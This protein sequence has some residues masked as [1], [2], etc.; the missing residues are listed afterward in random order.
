[1]VEAWD[2]LGRMIPNKQIR[3]I[4]ELLETG[5]N[6]GIVRL[7]D[8]FTYEDF[9]THKWTILSTFVMLAYQESKQKGE[10]VA[11]AWKSRRDRVRAGNGSLPCQ[12]P[13]WCEVANYE[14]GK[15]GTVRLIP[16]RAAAV[17]RIYQLAGQGYGAVRIIQQLT[18]EKIKP[19]S[20]H[21]TRAYVHRILTERLALGEIQL[22][23]REGNP[24]G[25][26]IKGYLPAVVGEDEYAVAQAA[27]KG[28]KVNGRSARDSKHV[29]VFKGMLVHARD[30][31]PFHLH[32]TGSGGLALRNRSGDLG[33]DRNYTFP[34][35]VFEAGI[36]ALLKEVDP[37]DV[38]PHA[39]QEANQA[40]VLRDQLAVIRSD[41][42]SI[43]E[44]MRAR[45]NKALKVVLDD[46]VAE[47]EEVATRLQEEL[48][49]RARTAE[50]DWE[51]LPNLAALV[52]EG[53]D[54][55]RLRL[56]PVLRRVIDSVWLLTVRRGSYLLAAVQVYFADSDAKRDHLL[57][58]QAAGFRRAGAAGGGSLA[59]AVGRD[60]LDLRKR[61][62]AAALEKRLA[63]LD[64]D[65]LPAH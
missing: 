45:Y 30:G 2:R 39:R 34:Y 3:L 53:G 18:T 59:E 62:D 28:R 47:E 61:G 63:A 37:R 20:R 21:W 54:E 46:K 48:A 4:E 13:A 6:I 16:E 10:R 17:R 60:D 49:R 19:F 56:R 33:T 23:D 42:A 24:D 57:V 35:P 26:P 58:Y 14:K 52:K 29:N 38:L 55:A 9:G 5:V 7:N 22:F 41:I 51:E 25:E 64:L 15:G 12:P 43:Q 1:V 36:L 31:G 40:Q 27:L 11:R 8:T 32:L 65:E 50:R 44:D